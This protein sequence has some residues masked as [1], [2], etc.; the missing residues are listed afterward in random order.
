MGHLSHPAQYVS[1]CPHT[2]GPAGC[3]MDGR[4]GGWGVELHS[5]H[6]GC[7]SANQVTPSSVPGNWEGRISSMCPFWTRP[8]PHRGP[9]VCVWCPK[10]RSQCFM[11]CVS[12]A[13]FLLLLCCRATCSDIFHILPLK[14][15]RRNSLF[16]SETYSTIQSLRPGCTFPCPAAFCCQCYQF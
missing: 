1:V 3:W 8:Q 14:R 13:R 9:S 16:F 12:L 7:V 4:G 15:A 6:R 11:T 10:L 5:F 2:A